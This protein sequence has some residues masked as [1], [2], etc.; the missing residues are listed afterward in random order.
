MSQETQNPEDKAQAQDGVTTALTVQREEK[1]PIRI[2]E[3]GLAFE[4]AAEVYRMAQALVGGGVCPKGMTTGGAMAAML[5][6][7]SLGLDEITSVTNIV[8]VNGRTQMAG[9]LLLA[10]MRRAGIDYDVWHEGEGNTRV[11][12]IKAWWPGKKDRA[13]ERSFSMGDAVRA[14][15]AGKDT[16]RAWP[17]DMLLWRAVARLCRQEFPEVGAGLYVFGEVPGDPAPETDGQADAPRPALSAPGPDPLIEEL[18]LDHDPSD[19]FDAAES[20]RVD[21]ELAARGS[22]E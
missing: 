5:K 2:G 3:R 15:L 16:Y 21:Q 6:G 11:A 12:H 8:V 9:S 10:L 20:T 17:D 19:A 14:G 7:R 4:S 1:A 18:K 22:E 13:K